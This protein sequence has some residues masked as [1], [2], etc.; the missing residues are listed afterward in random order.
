M[1]QPDIDITHIPGS[2]TPSKTPDDIEQA[3]TMPVQH[4]FLPHLYDK[5]NPLSINHN[6]LKPQFEDYKEIFAK[7]EKVVLEGDFT[8]G[9]SVDEFESRVAALHQAKYAIGVGSGTDA[10]FLSL[11]ALG[12]KDGD[13][14]ITTPYTFYATIGAIVT[15]GATPVFV[16]IGDDYNIDVSKIAAAVTEKTRAIVPVHWS[17][18]LCDMPAIQKIAQEYGLG[19]VEDACHAITATR[20]GRYAASFSDSAC[21]SLHPLKNLNVWGD[22]GF[23]VTNSDELHKQ[24]VLLR[25]HGLINRDQCAVFAYNS[26]L[27]TLQAVVANHLLDKISHIGDSRI[28]HALYLDSQLSKIPQILIPPRD[29]SARQVFH[30]YCLRAERRTEL[31]EFL[32]SRGVDAKIHYPI[33]MH[34]Q[35]AAA[36]FGYK[37]GDFPRAEAVCESVFSLPV[38]EFITPE[39]LEVMVESVKEFYR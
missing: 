30:I 7:I 1:A 33:P 34:L 3:G 35:P 36:S 9:R 39:Q 22:G 37:K 15:A 27:D 29:T 16:D 10:I 12:V 4:N 11:K 17:G 24:L 25:N 5:T 8:L 38:H 2:I 21:F 19:V 13:E 31:V 20:A 26:R 18:L 23:V 14:V 6:Y 32:I 28:K